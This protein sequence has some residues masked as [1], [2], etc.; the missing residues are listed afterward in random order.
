MCMV[1]VNLIRVVF[2]VVVVVIFLALLSVVVYCLTG[3]NLSS[4]FLK[5]CPSIIVSIK[6]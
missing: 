2:V 3:G 4:S 1:F 6:D 5:L